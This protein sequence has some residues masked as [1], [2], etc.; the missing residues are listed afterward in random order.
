VA[1]RRGLRRLG[2]GK[3]VIVPRRWRL[4]RNVQVRKVEITREVRKTHKCSKR[5]SKK[6][7]ADPKGLAREKKTRQKRAG[8]YKGVSSTI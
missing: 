5:Q 2:E 6:I 4:G 3:S 8:G 1:G 7:G